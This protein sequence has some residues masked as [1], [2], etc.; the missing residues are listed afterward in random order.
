MRSALAASLAYILAATAAW[1]ECPGNPDALGVARTIAI[2]PAEH[3]RLGTMQYVETLPLQDKEVVLTFDDGPLPPY[4]RRILDILAAECIK[5]TFFIV[6]QMAREY[7]DLVRRAYDEGHTIATHSQNHPMHFDR[8]PVTRIAEEID[9]GIAS[10]AAALGNGRAVAPFFRVPGLRTSPATERYLASHGLILWSADF[11]AD[12]WRHISARQV[13]QRALDRLAHYGK[14]ILLLHD[15]QPATALA[16]PDLLKALKVRGYR[17]VHVVPAGPDQP[18]TDT[19]PEQWTQHAPGKSTLSRA[20]EAEVTPQ[21]PVPS[22]QSFGWPDLFGA[23]ELVATRQ[24]RLRLTRRSGYQ[25]VSIVEA[26]WPRRVH[27]PPI[28]PDALP[29]PSLQSFGVPHP[30]GPNIML[31]SEVAFKPTAALSAVG[32]R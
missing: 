6:G 32:V 3:S 17:I 12:D 4:S 24:V 7:P 22:P 5:A 14:G 11:P 9:G 26:H 23:K 16:L 18:K 29:A 30:F 15:I 13:M 21:L 25:T 8:L 28:S 31:P 1:A 19:T 10:T 20:I 2:D 27:L